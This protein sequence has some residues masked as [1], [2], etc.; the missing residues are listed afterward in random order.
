[1]SFVKGLI[2]SG[3]LEVSLDIEK[4]GVA[5]YVEKTKHSEIF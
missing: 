2:S 4:L 5:G 1:V 3:V